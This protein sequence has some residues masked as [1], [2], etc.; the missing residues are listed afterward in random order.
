MGK[1]KKCLR[2]RKNE[3]VDEEPEFLG[4]VEPDTVIEKEPHMLPTEEEKG[5]DHEEEVVG[6]HEA[7]DRSEE[8]EIEDELQSHNDAGPVQQ[9]LKKHRGPT[10]MKDI[11]KDPN[12]RIRVDFTDLG[13]P[14]GPG[15]V[16]LSS[17][18]GSLVREHVPVVI[19]DW[20]NIGEER[21]TVLWKSV[22]VTLLAIYTSVQSNKIDCL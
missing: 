4:T 15:S 14:C 1:T 11:A 16:K 22:Q 5:D 21:R 12:T 20:R 19:A 3:S 17:Y 18:L 2:K 6:E 13:E 9:K 7:A 10:K 8:Q